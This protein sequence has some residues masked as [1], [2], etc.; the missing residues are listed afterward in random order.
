MGARHGQHEDHEAP[1]TDPMPTS[2]ADV[3]AAA[4]RSLCDEVDR[5]RARAVPDGHTRIDGTLYACGPVLSD[6]GGITY[7]ILVPVEDPD[8]T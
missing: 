8:D 7:T 2:Q 1:M 5:L 6:P 4:I 3:D